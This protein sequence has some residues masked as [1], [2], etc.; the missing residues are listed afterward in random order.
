MEEKKQKPKPTLDGDR[1]HNY[2]KK[3]GKS[4]LDLKANCRLI[5]AKCQHKSLLKAYNLFSSAPRESL[6]AGQMVEFPLCARLLALWLS[7]AGGARRA[8][9]GGPTY[10]SLYFHSASPLGVVAYLNGE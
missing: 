1:L 5:S 2:T 9:E 4:S 8:T 10:D 7:R 6:P 3:R